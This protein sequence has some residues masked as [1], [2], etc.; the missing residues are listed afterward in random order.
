MP[1]RRRQLAPDERALLV[2]SRDDAM[3]GVGNH[4]LSTRWQF[5]CVNYACKGMLIKRPEERVA[6]LAVDRHGHD[7]AVHKPFRHRPHEQASDLRLTRGENSLHRFRNSRLWQWPT[8]GQ[9][10]IDEFLHIAIDERDVAALAQGE[11]GLSLALELGEV[12]LL[13]RS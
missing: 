10:G 9:P 4:R 3:R 2:G 6:T 13:Q 8:E 11:R 5:I 7:D 1:L 12:S